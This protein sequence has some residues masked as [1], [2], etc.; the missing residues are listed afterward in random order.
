MK[1]RS[2]G[3]IFCCLAV[4]L[5]LSRYFIALWYRGSGHTQWGSDDFATYLGHTGIAPWFFA[6]AFLA[7]GVFYLVRAERE[8]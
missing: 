2:V 7:A 5:F 8:K 4:V 1:K 3:T 6:A